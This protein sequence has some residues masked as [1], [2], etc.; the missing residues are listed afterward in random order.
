MTTET[1][2]TPAVHAL[3][4]TGTPR[5]NKALSQLQG[6]LP[7]ITKTKTGKIEGENKQGKYFSYE[8]SYADLGDVVADVGPLLAKYGLAFHCGPTIN[9][10]D[11]REMIL[12]WALLHESGEEKT[13]EWPLGPVNQKPQSL[14]SAITYGRRYSFTAATN[15]VLEDD[16]DGQR[17]QQAHAGRSGSDFDNAS[18]ARPQQGR[19]RGGQDDGPKADPVAQ[20]LAKLA[21]QFAADPA[22]TTADFSEQVEKRAAGKDK[23]DAPVANPFGDGLVKL[24]DVLR[25]ARRRM[26]G[27][28]PGVGEQAE[29]T[30]E[31]GEADAERSSAAADPSDPETAWV[32]AYTTRLAEATEDG[33]VTAMRPGIGAAVKDKVI[34]PKVAGELSAAVSARRRELAE[35]AAA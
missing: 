27:A 15:I 4:V 31:A 18:T 12:T 6:E 7:R 8:Y 34:S 3:P 19:P 9:P 32:M 14:G 21:L 16:D 33:Q 5:L 24:R 25:E 20:A 22:K 35:A 30:T 10:A 28:G 11:R 2:E 17:A 13:G 23:L 26:Q 1:A 29:D